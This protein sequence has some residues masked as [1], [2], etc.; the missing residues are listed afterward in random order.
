MKK[1]FAVRSAVI[2][3][4][5]TVFVSIPRISAPTWAQTPPQAATPAAAPPQ[6]PAQQPGPQQAQE[7]RLPR[8]KSQEELNAYQKF[9]GEQNPDQQIKLIEDFLLQYPQTALKEQAY[10]AATQAYQAKNDFNKVMTYGELTL[11]ENPNNLVALL[12]LSSAIPERTAK[13]DL[14]RETK[15]N[16]AEQYARRGLEVLGKM[17]L[18]ANFTEEQ[19]SQVKRDAESTPHAALGMIALIREQFSQAES[20]FKMATEMAAKPDAVTLYRLG[21]CYSFQ[22]KYDEALQALD[23]SAAAGGVKLPDADGA[24]RDLVAEA[25]DFVVKSKAANETPVSGASPT[26][27]TAKQ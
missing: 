21:L 1:V 11:G 5:F 6:Q 18:P 15:L 20:E 10:Q 25:R 13:N 7:K 19:W 14:D 16:E 22:K 17:P 8:A 2:V 4:A 26:P 3:S 12:V 9:I 23:R 27:A 24:S